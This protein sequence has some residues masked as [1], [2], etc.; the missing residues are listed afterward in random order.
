MNTLAHPCLRLEQP[1]RS[2]ENVLEVEFAALVLE[3][4]V[5]FN[6]RD[7]LVDGE[8]RRQWSVDHSRVVLLRR[9]HARLAP[10]DLGRHRAQN[11]GSGRQFQLLCRLGQQSGFP[12]TD[13]G[14]IAADDI[15]PEEHEL[16]KRGRVE[17]SAGDTI[18]AQRLESRAHL[19]RCLGRERQRQHLLGCVH[20]G[21][22]T[23]RDSVCDRACF[24]RTCTGENT[25]RTDE[26]EGDTFLVFVQCVNERAHAPPLAW[27]RRPR[28]GSPYSSDM[29]LSPIMLTAWA[30]AEIPGLQIDGYRETSTDEL[31]RVTCRTSEGAVISIASPVTAEAAAIQD[32]EHRVGLVLS[33]G[34]RER[35]GFDVP[36]TLG[37]GTLGRRR[38]VVTEEAQ[39]QPLSAIRDVR[40]MLPSLA[41]ALSSLHSL[42][43]TIVKRDAI[44]TKTSL[45]CVR[46]AAGVIDRAHQT[47]R[48]PSA[49]LDRWDAAI[50]DHELWQFVPTITH[51]NL[52]FESILTA[53]DD[54]VGLTHW[55]DACVGDPANDL[56]SIVARLAPEISAG[57]IIDYIAHRSSNDQRVGHRARFLSELELA[58]WLVHGVETQDESIVDDAVTMLTNL[59]SAVVDNPATALGSAPA[60]PINLIPDEPEFVA[61][62]APMFTPTVAAP[63][64]VDDAPTVVAESVVEEAPATEPESFTE[65]FVEPEPTAAHEYI[66]ADDVI[67]EDV[68]VDEVVVEAFFS[69]DERE[70][71]PGEEEIL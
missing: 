26:R 34:V 43:T 53:G 39:G 69:D 13:L 50:E 60:K 36:H 58:R 37:A 11:V 46:E 49:L 52:E 2:D 16:S 67:V 5:P 33:A 23:E 41:L 68:I 57:F 14:E 45:D 28:R 22:D 20:T 66:P 31:D 64:F 38:V 40:P 24:T 70:P 32:R 55:A 3:L 63:A 61:P 18:D 12:G 71:V 25:H 51:G 19:A 27:L 59:V 9:E 48:V 6:Q 54:V 44:P 65:S 21:L 10:F 4:L 29:A 30:V 62:V 35:L 15:G 42:P 1:N 56:K 7:C 47:T 8:R 17:C